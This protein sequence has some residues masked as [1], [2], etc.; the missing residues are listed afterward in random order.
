MCALF[1]VIFT[2]CQKGDGDK[3]YGYPYVMMPQS[4]RIE[5]YYYV[6]GGSEEFTRN[7]IVTADKVSV[8]LGVLRSGNVEDEA[9]SVEVITTETPVGDFIY[10]GTIPGSEPMPESLYALPSRVDVADGSNAVEFYLELDRAELDKIEYAGRTFL[11]S[12]EL[13]NPT[14]YKLAREAFRTMVVVDVDE[15]MKG[16]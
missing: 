13:A 2:G 8:C 6:P 5:G 11:L 10:D 14:R 4:Q 9:F 15:L 7:Y 12:V 1:S 16:L 3:E